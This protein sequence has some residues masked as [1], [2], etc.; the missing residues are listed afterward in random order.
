MLLAMREAGGGLPRDLREVGGIREAE[1]GT[2]HQTDGGIPRELRCIRQSE[3]Q[4][5]RQGTHEKLHEGLQVTGICG[6]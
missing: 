4:E 5:K 1:S 3:A 6:G 2:I